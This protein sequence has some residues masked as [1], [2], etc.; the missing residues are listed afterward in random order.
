MEG[1][2]KKDFKNIVVDLHIIKCALREHSYNEMCPQS[3]F[4]II[5]CAPRGQSMPLTS[6][7]NGPL[8]EYSVL[9]SC[10]KFQIDRLIYFS[11]IL[12]KSSTSSPV[13]PHWFNQ[14]GFLFY[15]IFLIP[16]GVHGDVSFCSFSPRT[17]YNHMC[18]IQ[19]VYLI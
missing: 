13:L 18:N 1:I 8:I 3:I 4:H 6:E 12:T 7:Q 5:K 19:M 11:F 9:T 15:F 2:N 10:I 17:C 14:I 16:N